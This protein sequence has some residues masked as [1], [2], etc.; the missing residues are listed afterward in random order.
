MSEK[1]DFEQLKQ[2]YMSQMNSLIAQKKGI[3]VQSSANG[4]DLSEQIAKQAAVQNMAEREMSGGEKTAQNNEALT[5]KSDMSE[6]MNTME[7][8]Q[9]ENKNEDIFGN[10]KENLPDFDKNEENESPKFAPQE[11]NNYGNDGNEP[12]MAATAKG[13]LSVEVTSAARAVPIPGAYVIISEN[14]DDGNKLLFTLETDRDGQTR[15]VELATYPKELSND[16][17]FFGKPYKTYNV[18][19]QK[20]GFFAVEDLQVPVF[21]DRHSIQPINLIPI[22]ENY[23]GERVKINTETQ[24]LPIIK[25]DGESGAGNTEQQSK[26]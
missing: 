13:T 22:P 4:E 15:S 3:S 6:K 20:D 8:M 17:D 1:I 16:P 12:N 9:N 2:K 26:E 19:V 7:N 23:N 5:E 25:P 18:T 21:A 11:N 24:S 10:V 14:G